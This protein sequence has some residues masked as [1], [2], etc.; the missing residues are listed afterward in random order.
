MDLWISVA[1]LIV[2]IIIIL[3]VYRFARSKKHLQKVD[4]TEGMFLLNKGK[5]D[6]K[7]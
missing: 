4:D 3:F 2:I 5:H 7:R 6:D 1:L